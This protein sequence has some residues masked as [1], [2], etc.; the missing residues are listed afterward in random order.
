MLSYANVSKNNI[1]D[2]EAV[3]QHPFLECHIVHTN[4]ITSIEPIL[5]LKHLQVLL[6]LLFSNEIH[7]ANV[8]LGSR[9]FA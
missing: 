1:S 6:M 7:C 5:S 8:T 4:G 9:H 2:L 3:Q